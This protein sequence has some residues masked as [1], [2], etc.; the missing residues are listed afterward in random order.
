MMADGPANGVAGA[1][2]EM[3]GADSPEVR[4][5][6]A[7]KPTAEPVAAVPTADA[8]AAEV[9]ITPEAAKFIDTIETVTG[10]VGNIG[11]SEVSDG[12]LELSRRRTEDMRTSFSVFKDHSLDLAIT[13][14]GDDTEGRGRLRRVAAEAQWRKLLAGPFAAA[15]AIMALVCLMMYAAV[16]FPKLYGVPAPPPSRRPTTAAAISP[17]CARDS[18][19]R[20]AS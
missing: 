9:G 6:A 16:Y 10:V 12:M 8:E 15:Y 7:K 19:R 18:R 5:A 20:T 4:V 17:A 11:S 13:A 14:C 2:A 3:E 1:E